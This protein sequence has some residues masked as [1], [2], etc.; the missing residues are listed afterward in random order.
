MRAVSVFHSLLNETARQNLQPLLPNVGMVGLPRYYLN[1]LFN[2]GTNPYHAFIRLLR[3]GTIVNTGS[4]FFPP[5]PPYGSGAQDT[6]TS[7]IEP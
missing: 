5:F 4:S 2:C 3:F 1:K 7:N 6:D